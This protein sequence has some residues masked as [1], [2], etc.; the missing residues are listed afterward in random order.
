M[1]VLAAQKVL[2]KFPDLIRFIPQ[3][4]RK[5]GYGPGSSIRIEPKA[6][7]LSVIDQM[8]EATKLSIT[9][10]PTPDESKD[11][12]LN[13]ASPVVESG[14][15]VLVDGSWNDELI[16]EVCGFPAVAHDEYVDLLCYAIDYHFKGVSSNKNLSGFFR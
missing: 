16:T 8:R 7:G 9:R 2:M 12:R 10:T 4:V 3:F 1:Y 5:N 13:V 11:T 6:N 14:R 15:V